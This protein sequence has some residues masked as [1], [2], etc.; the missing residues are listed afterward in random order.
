MQVSCLVAFR[1][2]E[3]RLRLW[4]YVQSRFERFLPEIE[5]VEASDDGEDPFHKTVALNDAA[6]RASGDVFMVLDADTWV[7]SERVRL[8]M[9][10]VEETEHWVRPYHSKVKL[11][12]RDTEQILEQP[13]W[14]GQVDGIT[15]FEARTTYWPAPPFLIPRR[16]WEAVG[17]HD[18]RFRGWG[19]EDEAFALTVRALYGPPWVIRGPAVHLYHPR[20]GKSGKDLWPGQTGTNVEL[21]E[22]YRVAGRKA[23]T[24]KSFLESRHG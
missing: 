10:R 4:R 20:I 15:E 1:G 9:L 14:D 17:G 11:L 19:Q 23:A 2:D 13:D 24:M 21:A 8:A 16:M 3:H 22:E 5:V 6:R 18:E 7:Y 12:S